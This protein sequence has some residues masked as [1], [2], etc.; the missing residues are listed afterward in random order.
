[1]ARA[2]ILLDL[3][4]FI[5][6]LHSSGN[7]AKYI[8]MK[9]AYLS[10]SAIFALALLTIVQ[11]IAAILRTRREKEI[12]AGESCGCEPGHE[13]AHD[14]HDS[15]ESFFAFVKKLMVYPIFLFPIV[16]GYLFPVATLDSSI[17]KA[18]GFHFPQYEGAEDPYVKRQFLRPDTSFYFTSGDYEARM[19]KQ[20]NDLLAHDKT[21]ISPD[22]FLAAME[23]LYRFPERFMGKEIAFDGFIFH[24]EETPSNFAFVFRFGII[25]CIADAGVF[26]MLVELPEDAEL[27]NDQ[28]VHVNGELSTLYYQPFKTTI[29]YVKVKNWSLIDAPQEQYVYRRY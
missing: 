24:D 28:W 29:P 17:V 4:L 11:F 21:V 1:M 22:H 14:R 9:Y 6:H 16:T 3:T 7:I 12:A 27:D 23:T 26:G 15:S 19:Q 8:N 2:F 13:C 20:L 18:K 5:V 10:F 25:H